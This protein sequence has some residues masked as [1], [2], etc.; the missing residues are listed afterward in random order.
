MWSQG[1]DV[2]GDQD[3]GYINRGWR[4]V[5]IGAADEI[6]M[7]GFVEGEFHFDSKQPMAEPGG[8]T[9]IFVAAFAP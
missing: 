2:V 5:A 1:F 8:G 3:T 9:D 4:R 7:A 6:L